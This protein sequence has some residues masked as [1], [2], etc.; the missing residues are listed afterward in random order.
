VVKT[1]TLRALISAGSQIVELGFNSADDDIERVLSDAERKIFSLNQMTDQSGL[2]HVEHSAWAFY[3]SLSQAYESGDQSNRVVDTGLRDL[4]AMLAG[5]FSPGDLVILA[6]RP[7]MGKTALAFNIAT[8]IA[9]RDPIAVFSLEMSA[10][11]CTSRMVSSHS[12][13]PS[14]KIKS[15]K[16][17]T[18]EWTEIAKSVEHISSLNMFIDESS[19]LSPGDLLSKCRRLKTEQKK[20]GAIVIDYLQLMASAVDDNKNKDIIGFISRQLKLLAKEMDCPVIAL[21]QLSRAVESRMD[22]RPMMSDLRSSGE[23]E[24]NADLVM[25]LYRDEYYNSDSSDKG[26]AE[27]ILA[28]NRNGP[29]G[30][31]R[32]YF[33]ANTTTF[34]DLIL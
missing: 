22:K 27:L 17:N 21:S 15:A 13:I 29:T 3:E 8:H 33:E 26:V 1:S 10:E 6:A 2:S 12:K 7:S 14:N 25:F 32:L 5:G 18:E 23:I 19:L 34:K 24:Q 28:K 31:L 30:M 11:Q 16:L 20:L 4:N 9:S